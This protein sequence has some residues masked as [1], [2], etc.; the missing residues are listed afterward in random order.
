MLDDAVCCSFHP[1]LTG[2]LAV[3]GE[4]WHHLVLFISWQSPECCPLMCQVSF[5]KLVTKFHK[6]NMTPTRFQSSL[7]CFALTV[8]WTSLNFDSRCDI[9]LFL[10]IPDFSVSSIFHSSSTVCQA[11]R[12][13]LCSWVHGHCLWVWGFRVTSPHCQMGQEWRCCYPQWLL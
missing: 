7:I 10:N 12:E 5:N 8:P 13:H 6:E 9:I 2:N 4:A 1:P 11:A 3:E